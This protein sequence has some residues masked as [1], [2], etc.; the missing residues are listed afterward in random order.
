MSEVTSI[1]ELMIEKPNLRYEKAKLS[2]PPKRTAPYAMP[3]EVMV[4]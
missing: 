2:I 1:V 3:R 4:R